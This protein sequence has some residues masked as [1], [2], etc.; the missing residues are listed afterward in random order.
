MLG[1]GAS[2]GA[3]GG[4][5]SDFG[6]RFRGDSVWGSYPPGGLSLGLHPWIG[7]VLAARA[8]NPLAALAGE[9]DAAVDDLIHHLT[10]H[11][12]GRP[13]G[14]RG[15]RLSSAT[16]RTRRL[17]RCCSLVPYLA[18]ARLAVLLRCA[19]VHA[20]PQTVNSGETLT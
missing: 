9:K 1:G 12:R 5:R 6:G 3:G 8:G 18:P 11:Y 2:G 14:R 16:W 17:Q 4:K 15:A 7:L 20:Q 13:L 19:A 10:G